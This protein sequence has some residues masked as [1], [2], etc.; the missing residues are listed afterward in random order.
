MRILSVEVLINPK[1]DPAHLTSLKC[2]IYDHYQRFPILKQL[3]QKIF[4]TC[5]AKELW[6]YILKKNLFS[7]NFSNGVSLCC[8]IFS[9][10]SK[11]VIFSS[12][13][14]MKVYFCGGCWVNRMVRVVWTWPQTYQMQIKSLTPFFKRLHK[15][16]A[17]SD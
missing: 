4:F 10:L 3:I 6:I 12:A 2:K 8:L 17:K 5:S 13:S 11:L 16:S 9:I 15:Y 14:S 7:T 1:W